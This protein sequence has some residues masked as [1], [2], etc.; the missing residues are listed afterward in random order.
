[1][2]GQ[3]ER[4]KNV[5][6]EGRFQ[7]IHLG[8]LA[9]VGLLLERAQHVWLWVVANEQSSE[10]FDRPEDLPVPFFS[11][12]VDPHH[13]PEKNILP[14]WLRYRAVVET[15]R[16]EFGD[17]PI[18]VCGGRRL[19]LAWDLYEKILPPDRVFLT[20]DRDEFEDIKARAWDVMGE[21]CHRVD[22]S[23]LPKISATMVRDSI[24]KGLGLEGLL[25]PTTEKLL[26]EHGYIEALSGL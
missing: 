13:L 5:V 2:T 26:I 24:Q 6:W 12:A 23:A 14:F 10:V 4:Y 17:A 3:I 19:D 18:T 25:A 15:I 11:H 21:E 9:Y 22:V 16:A 1:V 8:H 7:P 20:P